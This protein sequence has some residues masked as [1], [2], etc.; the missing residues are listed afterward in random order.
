MPDVSIYRHKRLKSHEN[1]IVR[2]GI[3]TVAAPELKRLEKGGE[4][5]NH[6]ESKRLELLRYARILNQICGV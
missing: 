4:C 3:L 2:E 5:A 1:T 6:W